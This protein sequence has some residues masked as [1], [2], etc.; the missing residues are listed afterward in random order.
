MSR[1]RPKPLFKIE[2]SGYNNQ[3]Y[4]INNSKTIKAFKIFNIYHSNQQYLKNQY[5]HY[6]T[7]LQTY[8][9]ICIENTY[10]QLF[11]SFDINIYSL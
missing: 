6:Q 3:R 10:S 1:P 9:S 2:L 7:N 11:Y 4:R 5:F 8:F